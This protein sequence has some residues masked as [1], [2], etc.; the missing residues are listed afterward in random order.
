MKSFTSLEYKKPKTHCT[1]ITPIARR[2]VFKNILK[3]TKKLNNAGVKLLA[4]SDATNPFVAPGFSLHQELKL[5]VDSV[6]LTPI[7]ALKTATINAAEVLGDL[8]LG[9]IKP[10]CK[11]DMILVSEY[12]DADIN[13]ISKITHVILGGN[14]IKANLTYLL[15]KSTVR[16]FLPKKTKSKK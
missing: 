15:S 9:Q 1:Y 4:G 10:G 14:I 8:R 12:V 7:N 5:L 6:G 3:L 11:A 13:N 2:K 16:E